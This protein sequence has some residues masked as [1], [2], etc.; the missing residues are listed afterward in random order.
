MSGTEIWQHVNDSLKIVL[1]PAVVAWVFFV[2]RHK[3]KDRMGDLESVE[4]P[5][6]SARFA[7][8]NEID[9]TAEV[10]AVLHRAIEDGS[11]TPESGRAADLLDLRAD[12]EGIIKRSFDEGVTA[13]RQAQVA[14]LDSPDVDIFWTGSQ[15]RIAVEL[16]E[17]VW[18][19]ERA[20]SWALDRQAI[21]RVLNE[22]P[23][24]GIQLIRS[25]GYG[26]AGTSRREEQA[27]ERKLLDTM[28]RLY[29]NSLATG[30][31]GLADD[32]FDRTMNVARVESEIE[33][34]TDV[35]NRSKLDE[36]GAYSAEDVVMQ[37]TFMRSLEKNLAVMD[38]KSPLLDPDQVEMRRRLSND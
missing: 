22:S 10:E 37:R 8:R 7:T 12:I 19:V 23:Q 17:P 26:R 11:R 16:A 24:V 1:W 5:A 30:L 9:L 31:V 32:E 25:R 20:D 4:S 29:P 38:P 15:P 27:W 6:L 33:R 21:R 13:G 36:T 35:L 3:I 28:R 14:G 2:L 34:L 18:N